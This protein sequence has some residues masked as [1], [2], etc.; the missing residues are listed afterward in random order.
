M[1]IEIEDNDGVAVGFNG[2]EFAVVEEL[3]S[4]G[5]SFTVCTELMGRIEKNVVVRLFSEPISSNGKLCACV[6]IT[7]NLYLIQICE[8]VFVC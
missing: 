4:G 5:V 3:Q 7:C 8:R 2:T 6:D 1:Q